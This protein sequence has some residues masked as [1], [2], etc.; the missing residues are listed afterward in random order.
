[1]R[2]YLVLDVLEKT[3]A[4]LPHKQAFA[5]PDSALTFEEFTAAARRVGS[6]LT[7]CVKPGSVIGFYLDKSCAAL[8]GFFGAVYAGCA[9]AQLNLRHPAPR[10]AAGHHPELL[11]LR[12]TTPGLTPSPTVSVA[13][14]EIQ[15]WASPPAG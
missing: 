9:Y 12:M 4:R 11:L 13:P 14:E 10:I 2:D 3:A 15:S 8:C 7:G 6:A 5:D 1:M